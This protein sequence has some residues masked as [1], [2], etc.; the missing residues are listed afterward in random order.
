M[1]MEATMSIE[2]ISLAELRWES[3]SWGTGTT[4]LSMIQERRNNGFEEKVIKLE[5]RAETQN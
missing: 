2:T 1:R 3:V 4:Y 5:A